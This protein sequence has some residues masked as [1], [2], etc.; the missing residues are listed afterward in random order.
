[1]DLSENA[2]DENRRIR[3]AMR[4]LVVLSTLPAVWIG[5]GRDGIARSLADVLFHT[6]SLD[7]I[8]ICLANE[9]A[10][11]SVEIVRTSH[12]FTS[13]QDKAVKLSLGPLLDSERG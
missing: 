13:A 6:L 1:M 12:G 7:L 4:D 2:V 11:G 5:L 3:R 9:K 10:Q 8:Y